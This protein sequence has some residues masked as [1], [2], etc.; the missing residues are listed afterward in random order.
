MLLLLLQLFI[1]GGGR[2]LQGGAVAVLAASGPGSLLWSPQQAFTSRS[3]CRT[4]N[5]RHGNI[6]SPSCKHF[7]TT[8]QNIADSVLHIYGLAPSQMRPTNA[9]S[10]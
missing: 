1:G 8:Q 2:V 4:T 7:P 3:H 9:P 6:I 10:S 5:R